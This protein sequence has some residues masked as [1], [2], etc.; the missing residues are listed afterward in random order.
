MVKPIV[1]K[2]QF[3]NQLRRRTFP[4][5]HDINYYD[6][7]YLIQDLFGITDP[8][9]LLYL[10][11]RNRLKVIENQIDLELA[12]RDAALRGKRETPPP[13]KIRMKLVVLTLQKLQD[14]PLSAYSSI[15]SDS[16]THTKENVGVVNQG[17]FQSLDSAPSSPAPEGSTR[18]KRQLDRGNVRHRTQRTTEPVASSQLVPRAHDQGLFSSSDDD[19]SLDPRTKHL[20]R[21]VESTSGPVTNAP[22]AQPTCVCAHRPD[23]QDLELAMVPDPET[24]ETLAAFKEQLT[25]LNQNIGDIASVIRYFLYAQSDPDTRS[26][27]WHPEPT[28]PPADD[29]DA[30]IVYCHQCRAVIFG[31]Q[32][33]CANC[34]NF[35]LCDECAHKEH[36][37]PHPLRVV[38]E[39][40]PSLDSE[41]L[42]SVDAKGMAATND[43]RSNPTMAGSNVMSQ[44]GNG[45][46]IL[47]D[48]LRGKQVRITLPSADD[49]RVVPRLEDVVSD[50]PSHS[51]VAS[52]PEPS[53]AAP[54]GQSKH[55]PPSGSKNCGHCRRSILKG[56]P[57]RCTTCTD[58]WICPDCAQ[59]QVHRLTSAPDPKPTTSPSTAA[60]NL[61]PPEL[62]PLPP[63]RP[64]ASSAAPEARPN[65][66]PPTSPSPPPQI[67]PMNMPTPETAY[68]T[69]NQSPLYNSQAQYQSK[70]A[71]PLN[72]HPDSLYRQHPSP[73][74]PPHPSPG[75]GTSTGGAVPT[76]LKAAQVGSY[77]TMPQL[78]Y[79][80]G[81]QV[82]Y[83]WDVRNTSNWPWPESTHLVPVGGNAEVVGDQRSFH[84]GAVGPGQVTTVRAMMQAPYRPG[85]YTTSWRLAT[86]HGQQ[87]GDALMSSFQVQASPAPPSP[88][89]QTVSPRPPLPPLP[90]SFMARHR[91]MAARRHTYAMSSQ[92][93]ERC[94]PLFD[95][96]SDPMLPAR[97]VSSPP[98]SLLPPH[99][100]GMYSN[101]Y[102][103]HSFDAALPYHD[104]GRFGHGSLSPPSWLPPHTMAHPP[105]PLASLSTLLPWRDDGVGGPRSHLT[106]SQSMHLRLG[107]EPPLPSSMSRLP[108]PPPI[109][110]HPHSPP[111]PHHSARFLSPSGAPSPPPPLPASPPGPSYFR[112][113]S[114]TMATSPTSFEPMVM[115]EPQYTGS[116][117]LSHGPEAVSN[118]LGPPNQSSSSLPQHTMAMPSPLP[119]RPHEPYSPSYS[120]PFPP[121][122]P[123]MS[124][125]YGSHFSMP[126]PPETIMSG[127]VRI[128][129]PDVDYQ[130]RSSRSSVLPSESNSSFSAIMNEVGDDIEMTS[131]LL[132]LDTIVTSTPHRSPASRPYYP[133]TPPTPGPAT[134]NEPAHRHASYPQPQA[135][136]PLPS[137]NPSASQ[138]PFSSHSRLST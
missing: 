100:T 52:T 81:A 85:F 26:D 35:H 76:D 19:V 25:V 44:S 109:P 28:A 77:D 10:N 123:S 68:Q 59:Q 39:P 94:A 56:S 71:V 128:P 118:A 95:H 49:V 104:F 24:K 45:S 15:V 84:I 137:T 125:V 36:N 105:L 50:K 138:Y 55:Q 88:P 47:N 87:F 101:P 121:P 34:P 64:A 57:H 5:A 23:N 102:A 53:L 41:S 112:G 58:C 122:G 6:I 29:P 119:Q 16:T 78:A 97:F 7:A 1:L 54:S 90:Q 67:P 75:P 61:P 9:T 22:A 115:P 126:P 42:Q 82:I 48:S 113:P 80:P 108:P 92:S 31:P 120:M 73:R 96:Y 40:T 111:S 74:G 86:G 83:S 32:W 124:F 136:P 30:R 117:R 103:A 91:P 60:P 63:N 37:H 13:D 133:T 107:S 93:D 11:R 131:N 79:Q 129:S 99:P 65:L 130:P 70:T 18:A 106:A 4:N 135:A 132:S 43:G 62:P 72:V 116:R 89:R 21:V 27:F 114:V 134:F 38:Y 12:A 46:R 110:V 14:A 20:V 8:L 3:D 66:P 51:S 127:Q 98:M 69:A 2:F 17:R 33:E